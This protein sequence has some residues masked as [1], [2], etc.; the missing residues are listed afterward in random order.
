[1][2]NSYN[3]SSSKPLMSTFWGPPQRKKS[4]LTRPP[5]PKS[6]AG[7]FGFMGGN[8]TGLRKTEVNIRSNPISS[9]SDDRDDTCF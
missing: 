8:N 1:M 7:Y 6:E 9:N 2:D 4:T 3:A 5:S